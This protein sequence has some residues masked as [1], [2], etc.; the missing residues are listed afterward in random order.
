MRNATHALCC[1]D[2]YCCHDAGRS[3]GR[4]LLMSK[5]LSEQM[6]RFMSETRELMVPMKSITENL[7]RHP[8]TSSRSACGA[9]PVPAR[10][11]HGHRYRRSPADSTRPPGFRDPGCCR[12]DKRDCADRTGFSRPARP[13]S[14]GRR[15]RAWPRSGILFPPAEEY[16]RSGS[17]GRRAFH[18]TDGD[19]TFSSA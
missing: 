16:G 9:R 18:M 15:Q 8:R 2:R 12:T 14:C 7:R 11:R 19:P 6:E 4:D 13:R 10:R 3:A 5:R 17:P 1:P